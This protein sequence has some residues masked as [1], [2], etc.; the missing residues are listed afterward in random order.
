MNRSLFFLYTRA[1]ACIKKVMEYILRFLKRGGLFKIITAITGL[2]LLVQAI[3]LGVLL[4][5]TLTEKMIVDASR[6][7]PGLAVNRIKGNILQG[8]Q[9]DATYTDSST[10][11][12]IRNTHFAIALKCIWRLSLCIDQLHIDQL[13]ISLP[14][15]D[16]TQAKPPAPPESP[17]SLQSHINTPIPVFLHHLQIGRIT[18][19]QK[20]ET[21]VELTAVSLQASW[22]KNRI[23]LQPL[24][25]KH[26]ACQARIEAEIQ[27][28]DSLPLEVDFVC[29]TDTSAGNFQGIL[30]GDLQQLSLQWHNDGQWLH[31]GKV[32]TSLSDQ[33]PELTGTVTLTEPTALTEQWLAQQAVLAFSG[34]LPTLSVTLRSRFEDHRQSLQQATPQN[35]ELNVDAT[36]NLANGVAVNLSQ[37]QGR[38]GKQKLQATGQFLWLE[39]L[40]TV[41]QFVLQH[42][43]NTLTASGS[44]GERAAHPLLTQ[45]QWQDLQAFL[46]TLRGRI[47]GDIVIEG[48]LAAPDING[49]LRFDHLSHHA[50]SSHQE[51]AIIDVPAGNLMLNIKKAGKSQ[52]QVTLT[53]PEIRVNKT[54]LGAVDLSVSGTPVD[55]QWQIDW[56]RSKNE[57]TE[58]ACKGSLQP[59]PLWSAQCATFI[60]VFKDYKWQLEQ[61]LAI[62][63]ASPAA[64]QSTS[65]SGVD[66][67]PFCIKISSVSAFTSDSTMV[68][69][70]TQTK[71]PARICS[72]NRLVLAGSSVDGID[73]EGADLP[74]ALFNPWLP[75]PMIDAGYWRFTLNGKVIDAKPELSA[76]L[77]SNDIQFHIDSEKPAE[78]SEAKN[79]E[80]PA[81]QRVD[82]RIGD[83]LSRIQ[84]QDK[85]L[86]ASW[87]GQAQDHGLFN[88]DLQLTPSQIKGSVFI[89]QIQLKA[90][91]PMLT[92]AGI[93]ALTGT[94]RAEIRFSG[95][96]ALPQVK[97]KIL[98]ADAH[99]QL[100]ALPEPIT[101]I[102]LSVLFDQS[103]ADF[104]GHFQIDNSAGKLK[105]NAGWSE[106]DWHSEVSLAAKNIPVTVDENTRVS[107][108]PSISASLSPAKIMLN[109]TVDVP[110]ARI[111]LKQ[112]PPQAL[113]PSPDSVIVGSQQP[114][115]EGPQLFTD[116]TLTLG[117]DI[118]FQGFGLETGL[119]GELHILQS[120][121]Q[122]VEA[123]GVVH[124]HQGKYQAY[125]QKLAVR[126]GDLLFFGD[127][128]NPQLRIEAIKVMDNDAVTVG[129]RATGAARKP[130]VS[131]FSQPEMPQ[132]AK[133]HY[134]L[135]GQPPGASVSQ[136][137]DVM[138]AQAALSLGLDSSGKLADSAARKLGIE[139][140]KMS[141]ESGLNGPEVQL[142]GYLSSRLLVRYGVGVFDAVNSLSLRYRVGKNLYLEAV[143]GQSSSLDLLWSMEKE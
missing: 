140:F 4:S 135:T 50:Q 22:Q 43:K 53:V 7:I 40:L 112:I 137:S 125:G 55:H 130:V 30:H 129:L 20:A 116:I 47:Q 133:L 77:G 123:S 2:V 105:G 61:P 60:T 13:A 72:K 98:I 26:P 58:L 8:L 94:A 49:N 10:K 99:T 92:N 71:T 29:Q 54:G 12:E 21:V 69:S 115:Q 124:L 39:Q 74:W 131:L 3:V 109:G 25:M 5:D 38:F 139:Q 52:S 34:T 33:Q 19:R 95:K 82:W 62:R 102:N 118:E 100:A 32:V 85:S 142:S 90:F 59:G 6:E 57:K 1:G 83:L 31:Q 141:A 91:A 35:A 88:G 76:I 122:G 80:T 87:E 113:S 63:Y 127:V 96:P 114:A 81:A 104:S 79:S 107:L 41:K 119:G 143:S 9:F 51:G 67:E 134:L 128:D 28:R 103:Q 18:V 44:L 121:S 36:I 132:Q 70:T 37:L 11:I 23:N 24:T 120:P 75:Y 84:L 126:Q 27:L 136:D 86:T 78:E 66:I 117:D 65:Q 16:K 93:D 45:I 56:L 15:D 14:A 42:G 64:N 48:S 97:G 138:A 73:I 46:P 111:K 68:S 106:T 17:F 101:D 89:E 110:K 108:S